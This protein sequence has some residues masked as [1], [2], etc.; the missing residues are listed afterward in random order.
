M[1]IE[2][3]P[4]DPEEGHRRSRDIYTRVVKPTLKREDDWKFVAIDILSED[5]EMDASC[6]AA[7]DRLRL[8]RPNAQLWLERVGEPATFRHGWHG[9]HESPI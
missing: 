5:F 1:K 2:D 8:R 4:Y 6:L 7:A 9:P 3:L